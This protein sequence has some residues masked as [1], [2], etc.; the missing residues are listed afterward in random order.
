MSAQEDYEDLK[1]ANAL[2]SL[3]I[4]GLEEA[5]RLLYVDAV[6]L[7]CPSAI[8]MCNKLDAQRRGLE[9]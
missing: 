3:S 5:F 4:S 2:Q 7:G 8:E 1:F 9:A 6:K